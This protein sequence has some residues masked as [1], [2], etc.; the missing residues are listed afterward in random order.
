MR[1]KKIGVEN[2]SLHPNYWGYKGIDMKQLLPDTTFV[3][4]AE[5]IYSMRLI[6]SENEIALVKE[7]ARWGTVAHVNLQ[8]LIRPGLYDWEIA[9]ESSLI[10][11]RKMKEEL[12]DSYRSTNPS[13]LPVY[14]GFRGQVGEHSVFP[15]SISVERKIR[16]GDIR[17]TGATADIAG[18]HSELERNLFV[19]EQGEDVLTYHKVM[20]EMQEKAIHSLKPGKRCSDADRASLGV[21]KEKGFMHYILHHTGHGMGLEGHEAPFLDIGDET[22]IQPGMVLSVEPGLYVPGLGGFRHSDMVAIRKDGA[23]L[24]TNYSKQ[25]EELMVG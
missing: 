6:K 15:H 16:E 7:S 20:L 18:Y 1:G 24:I 23:E 21:A 2:L 8:E 17:G 12:G 11:S 19:G 13:L 22:I 5:D 14:A 3:F 4:I 25:A 10:A 9:T